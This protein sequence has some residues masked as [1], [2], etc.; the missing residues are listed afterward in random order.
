PAVLD[1]NGGVLIEADIGAVSAALLLAGPHHDRLDD[2]ALL[3][4]SAGQRV[5]NGRHDDVTDARVSPATAA[6]HADAQDLLRSGVIGDL[7]P[8]FLLDHVNSCFVT[9]EDWSG[10]SSLPKGL[11][12]L[13][14]SRISATR[15]RLVADV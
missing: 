10:G 3:D 13:A 12:Y 15:H 4:T 7:E 2:V 9:P 14:F 6:E 1:Q 5:L 8:R 11:S